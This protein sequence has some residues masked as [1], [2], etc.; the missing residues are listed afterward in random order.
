MKE[1]TATTR[2]IKMKEIKPGEVLIQKGLFT[3]VRPGK[4]GDTFIFQED[5]GDEVG[6][7]A[8]GQM[9]SL[10]SRQKMKLGLKYQITFKGKKDLGDGR[11]ANDFSVFQIEEEQTSLFEA[12]DQRA[13]E[14]LDG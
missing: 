7:S 13:N 6:L 14:F 3:E 2:Y 4:F 1:I 11:T 5:A 10:Y 12:E 8:G 9:K